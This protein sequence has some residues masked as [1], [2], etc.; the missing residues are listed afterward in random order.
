MMSS[1]HNQTDNPNKN[2]ADGDGPLYL[3]DGFALV[4]RSY[5]AMMRN[6]LTNMQG[7]NISA[8]LG[9]VKQIQQILRYA[10]KHRPKE[11]PR[12]VML[13]DSGE[14]TFRHK[15]YPE[16]KAN[17][18]AA[19]QDLAVQ[20]GYMSELLEKWGIPTYKISGYEADD[21]IATLAKMA[22]GYQKDCYIVTR[23]K[24]LYQ[25][26]D[27]YICIL[28][29]EK[30]KIEEHR[31]D[32]VIEKWGVE[33][34]QIRDYLALIGDSSDNIPG[35]KGIG[36]KGA[37][38]LLSQHK[39]LEGIYNQLEQ[40]QP[41]SMRKKLKEYREQAE[42]SYELVGLIHKV[43]ELEQVP[44][45]EL[46][47]QFEVPP[48][49]LGQQNPEFANFL[50]K[51]GMNQ[52]AGEFDEKF[53]NVENQS[54]ENRSKTEIKATETLS[55]D[56]NR[57]NNSNE[58]LLTRQSR[59]LTP[60]L[61]R[62]A[63][64]D[65]SE[66]NSEPGN[67]AHVVNN[68]VSTSPEVLQGYECI[69][70]EAQL[71]R[72]CAHI[73]EQK[74]VAID[75]ETTGLNELSDELV[76]ISLAIETN[77]ACYIPLKVHHNHES[78]RASLL[79]SKT[80]QAAL[81]D[82]LTPE[83]RVI[84]QHFKFDYKVLASWGLTVPNIYFDT[85]I[86]AWLLD[87][88]HPVGMDNL[89]LRYLNRN[90]IHFSALVPK[91]KKGQVQKSFA[92]VP[93]EQ[94]THYAAEDADITWQ[95][96]QTF[97]LMLKQQ[98]LEEL[99]FN[100]EMPL[101][102][103]LGDMELY[104]IGCKRSELQNYAAELE[105]E[106]KHLESIVKT[107]TGEDFNLN[108]PQQLASVLFDKLR[109]PAG[110]KTKQG[111][112]TDTLTL[113]KLRHLHPTIVPLLEFRRLNKLYSTY[114]KS[115]PSLVLPRTGRIHTHFSLIG[116]ETGRLSC[117]DPNLQN[118]PVKDMAG[119]RI[120]SAF[121]PKSGWGFFSADY[122][123]IELVVLAHFSADS[124]LSRAFQEG[125][126]IHQQT[127]GRL[128]GIE[129]EQVHAEQRRIAKS[130][131]FGVIYGMSAFRLAQ[132]LGL[133]R[134]D[135]QHFIDA[136]FREFS[137]VRHFISQV[138]EQAEQ[139]GFVETLAGRRREIRQLHSNNKNERSHGERMAINTIIQGSAADIVKRA[140]ILLVSQL[141]GMQSRLVLQVH[142][143]L[144]FEI[145]LEEKEPL[146]TLILDV[147]EHAY[148]L[149]VPLKVNGEWS[150]QSWGELH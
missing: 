125:R 63:P 36:P 132:D 117:K 94:A 82:C 93:L 50:F 128:F 133:T 13:L 3:I 56:Q 20:I 10:R 72:W 28:K 126:D 25:L 9:S 27:D 38:K 11:Y 1:N 97:S 144:I 32:Y 24:D 73:T 84:G 90:T 5:Y 121:Q 16:Y 87:S 129:P 137:G 54:S 103:I 107:L 43:P 141:E 105:I 79:S 47:K 75:T 34:L 140:M 37:V 40:V 69:L 44:W 86:A 22:S 83:I 113:E 58:S 71:S 21:L 49:V 30:G 51:L 33:P 35:V 70:N 148:D 2:Q 48:M 149:D 14:L 147:M 139:Q 77:R 138:L 145:P 42:I 57:D 74:I 109:L 99:F 67:T 120:R 29:L 100:L 114:V 80:V 39:S 55:S 65:V 91:A 142:D 136:Y 52:L 95:L 150:T 41:E 119:R 111:Y 131:N 116:T 64:E 124:G 18:E 81:S 62:P 135:A 8:L 23:D 92:D 143:E 115:L 110:K 146:Q 6:P 130:I 60:P 31:Q 26:I 19:P 88:L 53:S 7:E 61:K 127:A 112:S 12:V 15:L 98:G 78:A 108:S 66:T 123:Q 122:S 134:K 89:A 17:R 46:W 102:R 68:P 101:V 104:G 85:M 59:A 45:P 96:Y 4:F 106:L 76:G 118:I